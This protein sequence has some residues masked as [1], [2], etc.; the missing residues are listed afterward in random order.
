[1]FK[2]LVF[3]QLL[4]STT[5]FLRKVASNYLDKNEFQFPIEFK[6]SGINRVPTKMN[7]ANITFC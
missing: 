1:V 5:T 2:L 4:K 6:A 3:E 7:S